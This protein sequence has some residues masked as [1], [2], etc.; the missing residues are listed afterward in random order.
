MA[1]ASAVVCEEQKQEHEED[2][3]MTTVSTPTVQ[4][5]R[6]EDSEPE[7]VALENRAKRMKKVRMDG[8][9]SG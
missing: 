6:E 5:A 2:H 1:P 4:E 8:A 9:H 7:E 3:C